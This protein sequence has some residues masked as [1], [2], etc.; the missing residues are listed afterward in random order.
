VL[1]ADDVAEQLPFAALEPHHLQLFDRR[2]VGRRGVDLD[3]GNQRIRRKIPQAGGL[4][5]LGGFRRH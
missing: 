2:V 1:G 4:L 3:A 5:G